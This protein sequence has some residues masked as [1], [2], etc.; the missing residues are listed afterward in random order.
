[1]ATY[2]P[3][4]R[5]LPHLPHLGLMGTASRVGPKWGWWGSNFES[6]HGGC[7]YGKPIELGAAGTVTGGVGGCRKGP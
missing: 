5:Q 3:Q 2:A 4:E 7:N 1:M 6:I